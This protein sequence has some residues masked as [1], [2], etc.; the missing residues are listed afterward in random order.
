V[1]ELADIFRQYGPA[2]REKFA[3]RMPPSHLD[4]MNDIEQCR[5]EALGGQV[6][7]CPECGEQ[8]YSYHSCQNRHCPKC[9][10]AAGQ[11][12]LEQQQALLLPVPYFL[13]TFTLPE[14]LR[15]V[16]RSHQKQIYGLLFRA[17]A[18]AAQQLAQDQHSI[19]G[20]LGM[21]GVL[22]TWT[23]ALIY[24]PHIH[25]VVPGGGLAA[26][27][28]AWRPARE[29]FLLPVRALS[30]IFRAKFR[31]ALR[32]TELFVEVPAEL[33]TQDWVVHCQPVGDGAHAL[34][35]LAPYIFRVAISNRRILSLD[36]DQ[37]TFGYTD[38]Q[39]GQRKTCTVSAEEFIRRFLQHVLPKGLAKVRYYGFYSPNQRDALSKAQQLLHAS[40][41]SGHKAQQSLAVPPN[42]ADLTC[43]GCGKPMQLVS[44][45][46]PRSRCPPEAITK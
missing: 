20:T 14:G 3:E 25:Y 19:G 42:T 13:L 2:Y 40:S 5:T 33:W 9:Q 38:G 45:I 35:Y 27:G 36:N 16:A 46:R 7:Q 32:Q 1:V 15:E 44:T 17:S 29:D 22:H 4:A 26:D 23:R 43:P 12:W 28:T 31:D 10:N 30:V 41:T 24:H 39:S 34:K 18:A 11:E 6:Y 37:V 21:I 8:R